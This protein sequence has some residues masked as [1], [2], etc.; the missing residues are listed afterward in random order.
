M[1]MTMIF[2]V[3]LNKADPDEPDPSDTEGDTDM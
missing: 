3:I 2:N 1:L